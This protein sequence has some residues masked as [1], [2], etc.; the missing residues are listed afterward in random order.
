[1]QEA[2]RQYQAGPQQYYPG[3][4]VV[5]F[6]PQTEQALRMQEQRALSGSPITQQAQ[7]LTQQTLGGGFLG[8]SPQLTG[9][10]ERALAPAQARVTS[11]LA[12]RGRLGSGAAADVMSQALGD[13][14]ADMAYR[15]YAQERAYQQ[16]ALRLAPSMADM[17]YTDIGRLAQVGGLREEQAARELGAD[18]QRFEFEQQAQQEALLNY[19]G[20][21]GAIDL[22]QTQSQITP[23]F[24]P[25]SA[26][27]FLGG[28][29]AGASL[30]GDDATVGQ[31]LGAGAIGGLLARYL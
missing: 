12:Q 21:I 18:I 6:A 9:A 24:V 22:G 15:D 28:A 31:R 16:D 27:T 10:I 26:Q 30:L 19:L 25:S 8:G 1:M 2:L 29:A 14:A 17:S 3:S 20:S 4:T 13:I 7:Q 5:G 23:Y 11:G